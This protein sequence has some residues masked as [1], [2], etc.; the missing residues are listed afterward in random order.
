MIVVCSILVVD[1][2]GSGCFFRV[3]AVGSAAIPYANSFPKLCACHLLKLP[4]GLV[5]FTGMDWLWNLLTVR[6]NQITSKQM[7]VSN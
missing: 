3:V 6:S 4:L 1:C 2:V 7:F 5:R